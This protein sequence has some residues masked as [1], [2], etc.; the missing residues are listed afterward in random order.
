VPALDLLSTWPVSA[1]AA[2]YAGPDGVVAT[3]GDVEQPFDLASVTK[4]LTTAALLVAVEE[5]T[6]ALDEPAGGIEGVTLRHL[7]AHT[8]GLP[9]EGSE[10]IAKPGRRRIYSNVGI[11]RAADHLA[12]RA[13]MPFADYLGE[14]VLGPLG[15]GATV[16][17][18]RSP[19][20]GAT[21]TVG[22]LLRFGRE[23]LRPTLIHAATLAEATSVQYPS[24]AG[25]VP[26]FGRMDPC[27]WGLGFELR[28]GKDPHWTGA[29]N[30]AA[31]FG[32]FGG[33]GTFLWVDPAAGP[34][35][36]ACVA[37]TDEPFD[38]WAMA[39][40]P[41]LA[42]AVVAEARPPAG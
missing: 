4:L 32:H 21:S 41:A 20:A 8:S 17:G 28:D 18:D 2:G 12:E 33:A 15:M 13:G 27:D 3:A 37:L 30:S 9:F 31:T 25:V 26:G 34:D 7:L 36:I 19:A 22:D 14:A 38:R 11:E 23:L 42:D 39:C 10:P 5:G 16:L 35:G 1:A 40:W 24:L 29:A 6:V